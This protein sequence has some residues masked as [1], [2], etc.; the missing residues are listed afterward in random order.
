MPLP[1]V[2]TNI[3]A[4]PL[5]YFLRGVEAAKPSSVLLRPRRHRQEVRGVTFCRIQCREDRTEQMPWVD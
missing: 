4:V 1:S 2:N 3:N 5:D